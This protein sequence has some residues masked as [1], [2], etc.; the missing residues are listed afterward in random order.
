LVIQEEEVSVVRTSHLLPICLAACAFVQVVD[1]GTVH[2]AITFMDYSA[3]VC[4][5]EYLPKSN[6]Y[7]FKD[8]LLTLNL[9][10]SSACATTVPVYVCGTA[11]TAE[12]CSEQ[13][14]T[15]DEM[16]SIMQRLDVPGRGNQL[17]KF[18]LV[19]PAGTST[20]YAGAVYSIQFP[21]I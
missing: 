14:Y 1:E 20:P 6:R 8:T 19:I 10:Q 5:S 4:S 21:R 18:K 17:I 15:A 7:G 9:S 13:K 3:Y 11:S 12:I 16:K 2:A